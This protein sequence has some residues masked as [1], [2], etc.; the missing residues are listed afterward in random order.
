MTMHMTQTVIISKEMRTYNT[1]HSDKVRI[2]KMQCS[3]VAHK[4]KM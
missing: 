4:R 1:K 2:T 3:W